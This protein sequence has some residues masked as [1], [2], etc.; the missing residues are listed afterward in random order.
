MQKESK[1]PEGDLELEIQEIEIFSKT[2]NTEVLRETL[3]KGCSPFL[4][5]VCC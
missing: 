5:V 3:T 1:N 2:T 4:T